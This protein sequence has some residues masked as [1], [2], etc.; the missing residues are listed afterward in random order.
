[1]ISDNQIIS[2]HLNTAESLRNK[3][4]TVSNNGWQF[5]DGLYDPDEDYEIEDESRDWDNFEAYSEALELFQ[6][7]LSKVDKAISS[8]RKVE[9][10]LRKYPK[11]VQSE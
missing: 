11:S 4:V 10:R 5:V 1:M 2:K 7:A 8:M 3:L 9:Y 6:E